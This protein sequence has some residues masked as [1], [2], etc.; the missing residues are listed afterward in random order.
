MVV[1]LTLVIPEKVVHSGW[2]PDILWGMREWEE[3]GRLY[4]LGYWKD[5]LVSLQVE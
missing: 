3:I 5:E 2:S 4:I 1:T